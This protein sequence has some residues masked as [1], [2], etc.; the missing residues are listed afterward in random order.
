MQ[1]GG[2]GYVSSAE[3]PSHSRSA[4]GTRCTAGH[5]LGVPHRYHLGLPRIRSKSIPAVGS[6]ESTHLFSTLTLFYLV[7]ISRHV[8]KEVRA[9]QHFKSHKMNVTCSRIAHQGG[10]CNTTSLVHWERPIKRRRGK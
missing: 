5:V 8:R 7:N 3:C 1:H 9:S 2:P 4:S 6:P 10:G